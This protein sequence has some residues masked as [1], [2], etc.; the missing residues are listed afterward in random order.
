M[1]ASLLFLL[2]ILTGCDF[3][4]PN[5]PFNLDALTQQAHL[6][7]GEWVLQL[8]CGELGCTSYDVSSKA[9]TVVF[10]TPSSATV[11][12]FK[13]NQ[14]GNQGVYELI[15][16]AFEGTP[17]PVG[18]SING[19]AEGQFGVSA[20]SLYLSWAYLDGQTD[21]YVRSVE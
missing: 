1:K 4:E 16:D 17:L 12:F 18:L 11:V 9:R 15:E 14:P 3:A 10:Y 2:F 19:G 13:K 21:Y 5:P 7:E 20:E 8:S 6:L